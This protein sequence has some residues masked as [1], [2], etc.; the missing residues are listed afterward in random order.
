MANGL[1]SHC[2][3]VLKANEASDDFAGNDERAFM[4]AAIKELAPRD[5]VERMLAV[6]MAATHVAMVRA[7]RWLALADT[8]EKATAYNSNYTKLAR[9]YTAQMEALRKHRNGGKQTVT[10]QHVNVE[11]G[12]QA[13]VG[14]VHNR[15]VA[16]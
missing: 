1:L 6:Q 2:L 14:N 11:G 5:A 8:V 10:V 13:I 16:D 15:E 9:T 7:G 4:L 3:K 12:G